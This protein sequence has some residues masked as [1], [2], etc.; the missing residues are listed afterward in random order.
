M[1]ERGEQGSAFG[2][3]AKGAAA[4]ALGTAAMTVTQAIEMRFTG[5]KASLV[6]GEVGARLARMKVRGRKKRRLSL[7]VHWAHGL[8]GGVV[9]G[10]IGLTPLSGA[11]A[12]AA[13]F[14]A[15]W[16]SDVT[17]YMALGIAAAP[18]RWDRDEL[19]VD[20]LHKGVY[21]A[22]T[23]AAFERLNR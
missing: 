9:R 23:S 2:V 16:G 3:L 13:H 5:R 18:W 1:N 8:N 7:G 11:S 10:L 12:S 19:A 6:P 4:G 21:A 17:L 22:V 20:L 14:A 15:L